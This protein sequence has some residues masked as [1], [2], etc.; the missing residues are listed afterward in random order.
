MLDAAIILERAGQYDRSKSGLTGL[1]CY[2]PELPKAKSGDDHLW[3]RSEKLDFASCYLQRNGIDS[4][5]GLMCVVQGATYNHNHSNGMSMELY[6]AG[7]VQGIDP[8]NG[9]TYEHPM[10]VNY[11][12]QWAAHNTVVA[13]G[14]STSVT[15]FKGGGGTKRIG[16]VEL[17]SMEPSAGEKAI[18]E[19]FS[20]T[21]TKYYD[22]STK[23]NQ[24]RLLSILRID[25]KH[26]FYVDFYRSDNM[27]SNDYLYHNIGDSVILYTQ[28]GN[29]LRQD[30]VLSYPCVGEDYPGLRYFRSVRT[31]GLNDSTVVALFSAR[32]LNTGTS[33]MKMWMPASSDVSYFTALAPG[34]KTASSPYQS[35]PSLVVTMRKEKP[36]VEEPFVA[37][38]EPISDKLSASLIESVDR[39]KL[40]PRGKEG[41]AIKVKTKEGDTFTLVNILKG[42]PVIL[43][44]QKCCADFAIFA[45]RKGKNSVYVGNGFFVENKEFKVESEN[46]GSFY[47]EYDQTS[48]LVR[49]NCPIKIQAKNGMLKKPLYL[50][51]GERVFKM[52]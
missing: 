6:G 23:T 29:V 48:L 21:L 33:Y 45:K 36:A 22:G 43:N 20:Y 31:T 3:N 49:S 9:P 13:A 18:S 38:Y 10:H 30:E 39:I 35:K 17:V 28:D 47:M 19:E 7:T 34:A 15:P 14:A 44:N 4:Q 37:V 16:Q 12:T 26:G 11:Y 27:I 52:E 24:D 41:C 46:R 40:D 25:E 5:D 8:G 1:L 51:G 42:G 50:T 32:L 2:L